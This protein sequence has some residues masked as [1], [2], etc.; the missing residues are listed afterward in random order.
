MSASAIMGGC[1]DMACQE[2]PLLA[3]W[4]TPYQ[5]PPFDKIE[6]TDYEPAFDKAIEMARQE[7]EA[8]VANEEAPTFENTI[9][10]LEKQGAALGRISGIFYN[11]READTS[12]E[13]DAIALRVQ[14][15]LTAL[16]NDISLNPQLFERV[17]AV[18]EGSREGLSAEDVRLLEDTYKGFTRSGAALSDEDKEL[19]REYTTALSEATLIFGQNALAATNAFSLNITDEAKVAELPEF[20]REALAAEAKA[21]GEEGWTVTL[22]APSYIP[23]MTYSSQ[24]AE[25]EQLYRAYNSR[26]L[27]GEV[28]NTPTI[29]KIVELRMKIAKLFGYNNYAE[30]VLAERMAEN[31]PTVNGFLGELSEATVE[32]ARKDYDMIN[33]YAK[34]QGLQGDVMPWDWAYYTEK[35][36]TEKYNISD[37]AVKP[38]LKLDNVIE[39]VFMAATKLYGI[40]FTPNTEIAVYHP[41]VTAYEVKDKDGEFL[42]VLYLDFFPRASKRSGAWMTEFRG[43][44]GEGDD[45]VRPL[46]SLVM[47][48]TKPTETTPSLLTF[49]EFETFLHE[50]GHA[51]HGMLAKGKYESLNGTN[52]YRDFVEL[53]SQIMENWATEKEYLDLWAKHYQ[54]G[55]PI[56]AELI[57]RIV[58]AKN[59]LAAYLNVRQLSFGL[60]DMAWHTLQEPYAGEIEPFERKAMASVQVTPWVEGTAMCPAFTHIFS[61]GYAAG[62][63]GYK[64]AEVLAA[65]AFSLFAEKGIFNAEAS[66]A[67]RHLLEQGGKRHPMELYVEF[68]GHKP[69]TKALIESMD[70]K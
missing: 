48:F 25:K 24:R 28:D 38:Y 53:P 36:K 54:T 27:G 69:E 42:A 3:E 67:F 52:V 44:K 22:Q 1:C 43:A 13:M 37:E 30:Y 9:V 14:P 63:Y 29:H 47:N 18:Y 65:D 55:E 56:P 39:G 31:V 70:L 60:V 50:F 16:G 5:T 2:N 41:D 11:L 21:R 49:D 12:D 62:Y 35:Y 40:T 45:E 58:A 26:A 8:I 64:W 34:Q 66:A 6:I 19:Y 33:A 7:V 23:F 59:Y 32:Y 10:A 46:V 68:R 57:E 4:D 17:K 20:V 51:L 61:G 15:K